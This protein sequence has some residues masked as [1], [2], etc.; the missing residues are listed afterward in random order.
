VALSQPLNL[1]D[2]LREALR[3]AQ[4][5]IESYQ[6][7]GK[8]RLVPE[9]S[10]GGGG[11]LPGVES[12][13]D[14]T[15]RDA[16]DAAEKSLGGGSEGSGPL[17]P[18]DRMVDAMSKLVKALE[19]AG[20]G[21]LG[22]GRGRRSR[23]GQPGSS[24]LDDEDEGGP[25]YV[26]PYLLQGL[27]QN[28]L[29]TTQNSLMSMLMGGAG[30]GVKAPGWMMNM[31]AGSG[32]TFAP[33][34]ALASETGLLGAGGAGSYASAGLV[35]AAKVA[36]PVAAF[37]GTMMLQVGAAKDRLQDATDWTED[38]RM[39]EGAGFNW[40]A[41]AWDNQFTSR[42]G[43]W[44]KDIRDIVGSS[45]LGFGG[46]R[47]AVGDRGVVDSLNEGA[48]TALRIGV[49][50]SQ[51]GSVI[52]A[53]VR[54]G[55]FSLQGG[56]AAAQMTRYL[57]LIE[58]WTSKTATFGF[59]SNESLQKL[60]EISQKGMMGTNVLTQGAQEALLSMDAR[61]RGRLP[62]EQQ[63]GVGDAISA[64]LGAAPTGDTQTVLMMNQFLGADGNLNA[65]GEKAAALAFT[66]QRVANV[67]A[68]Y[69]A[70]A[71]TVLAQGLTRSD[72]GRKLGRIGA[73]RSVIG[74]GGSPM[75]AMLTMGSTEDLVG[76]ADWMSAA[77][78]PSITNPITGI[79][80]G[81]GLRDDVVGGGVNANMEQE[82]AQLGQVVKRLSGLTSDTALSMTKLGISST[83]LTRE[84]V[85]L[86]DSVRQLRSDAGSNPGL[87][88]A[89]PGVA[90]LLRA[91]GR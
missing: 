17:N 70:M 43:I 37:A 52:G 60:A 80:S 5:V 66:P 55:S 49:S 2:R 14:R 3:E 91:F 58:T 73:A 24:P 11:G 88:V 69:G 87:M 19:A 8:I 48:E 53:G 67:K 36:V 71:G 86:L 90:G 79:S 40:R 76:N 81:A 35:G 29:G 38:K 54:S 65:E 44:Q 46:M 57:A 16:K 41:G 62:S 45:G 77:M 1:G 68:Q 31:L 84:F 85:N 23:A 50:S 27:I 72:I 89:S 59:S 34:A 32:G 20:G 15:A 61:I 51:V 39:S 56:D 22:R 83:Q 63:R 6:L 26:N 33:G 21:G 75:Q 12:S 78:D 13:M 30:A 47:Q 25:G 18:T 4:S 42:Q 64:G 82:L 28:P 10:T 74:A 7:E 9:V